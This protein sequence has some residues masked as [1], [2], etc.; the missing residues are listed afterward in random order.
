MEAQ[1]L[2]Q[3]LRVSRR[4]SGSGPTSTDQSLNSGLILKKTISNQTIAA[5]KY[6]NLTSSSTLGLLLNQ[7]RPEDLAATGAAAAA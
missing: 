1:A 2:V 3:Q 7:D 6:Q 5:M 4:S